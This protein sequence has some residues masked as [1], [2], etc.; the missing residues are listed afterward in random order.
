LLF[1]R[2]AGCAFRAALVEV[3]LAPAFARPL[4]SERRVVD[5]FVLAADLV[6][7]AMEDS[8]PNGVSAGH[9]AAQPF[10][11]PDA[12]AASGACGEDNRR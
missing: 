4:V 7:R 12:T 8:G 9:Q 6:R 3:F 10:D 1:S 11:Q 2:A 5:F